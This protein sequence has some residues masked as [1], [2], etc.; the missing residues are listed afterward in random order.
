MEALP[1]DEGV[2]ADLRFEDAGGR[3]LETDGADDDDAP[4]RAAGMG[5]F[6]DD[7]GALGSAG[8]I[9]TGGGAGGAVA[10]AAA[11][12]VGAAV[13]AAAAALG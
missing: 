10:A 5:A 12:A 3:G 13:A 8:A 6:D 4:V 1:L 7:G 11:A 9:D 2:A